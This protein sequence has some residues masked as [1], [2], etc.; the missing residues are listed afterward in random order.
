MKETLEEL[1]RIAGGNTSAFIFLNDTNP[2]VVEMLEGQGFIKY[3]QN[4]NKRPM[5]V[6][7]LKLVEE[8]AGKL[9]D[10]D[11]RLKQAKAFLNKEEDG[12]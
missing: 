1:Y 8:V 2:Q 3:V 11:L 5:Y 7:T 9:E 6:I 12:E 10:G 4:G